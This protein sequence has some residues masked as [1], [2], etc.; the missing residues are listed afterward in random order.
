VVSFLQAFPSRT[1]HAFFSSP[2]RTSC[3]AQ[4]PWFD[5]TNDIWGWVQIVNLLIVQL[6]PFSCYLILLGPTILLRTL[7]SNTFSLCCSLNVRDQ[8]SHPY[9]TTGRIMVLCILTFTFLDSR[10]K[11]KS[12]WWLSQI[13]IFKTVN[14]TELN[15]VW[16]LRLRDEYS[17]RDFIDQPCNWK[18][19]KP[20]RLN[21][22]TTVT[23][24]LK[25]D[26]L[27]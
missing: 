15:N 27:R 2:T 24:C 18:Q 10:R 17:D 9:K 25:S 6:P 21:S 11:D 16:I 12:L 20:C 7:F 4:P 22:I 3:P 5:L 1:S 23:S 19:L 26:K 14:W 8:V 13:N